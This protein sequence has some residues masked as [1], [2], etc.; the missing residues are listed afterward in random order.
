LSTTRIVAS[1]SLEESVC[2]RGRGAAPPAYTLLQQGAALRVFREKRKTKKPCHDIIFDVVEYMYEKE[3]AEFL[4]KIL[5][6]RQ[7]PIDLSEVLACQTEN[8]PLPM[9]IISTVT[10]L[11]AGLSHICCAI[12]PS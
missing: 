12:S 8:L 11:Y 1:G 7:M 2:W 3:N 9:N 10:A 6:N 5:Q 4:Q